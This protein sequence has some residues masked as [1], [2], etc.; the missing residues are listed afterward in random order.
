MLSSF[1]YMHHKLSLAIFQL[2]YLY[3][4]GVFGWDAE[5]VRSYVLPVL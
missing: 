3:A 4:E 5:K 1:T 2:K